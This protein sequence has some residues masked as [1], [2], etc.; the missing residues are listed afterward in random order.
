[1]E[2]SGSVTAKFV[3]LQP[4]LM[5]LDEWCDAM[6]QARLNDNKKLA[7]DQW[8]QYVA[9][10]R[11]NKGH[12]INVEQSGNPFPD[13]F[14]GLY[15]FVFFDT[16]W[17]DIMWG[18]AA[19]TSHELSVSGGNERSVFRLSGRYMYDDSNLKWGNN[20]NQR[21]NFRL[22]NTFHLT[23]NFDL[24]SIIFYYRQDQVSPTQIGEALTAGTQQPGFPSSTMDG[25]PYAWGNW[26][27]PNWRC[28]LGGDNKLNTS[29]INISE[30]FKYRFDEHFDA[31]ATLGY[32]T[33]TAIRDVK[34]QTV[35]YYDYTGTNGKRVWNPGKRILI[36]LKQLHEPIC[37]R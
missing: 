1:M 23:K 2:Y 12:Y 7:D 32:N 14:Q 15:D 27:T 20:K 28:E 37:I 36:I 17:Q 24:E 21:Y 8:L 11:Q 5:T 30:T 3:G 29:G 19:S 4:T 13:S 26:A 10:A 25:K 31:V 6:E 34:N 35:D 9:L 22:S 33:S 18:T 16:D